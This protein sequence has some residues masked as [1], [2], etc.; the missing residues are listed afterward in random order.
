MKSEGELIAYKDAL[1]LIDSLQQEQP[2]E[3]KQVIII[4]ETDGDAN[5]YWDCRSLDDVK[6]L[7]ASAQSF[8]AD[9]QVEELRGQGS[10]PDYNTTEGRS[11]NA[12]KSQQ[13]Q[14]MPD[15]TQL[16]AEWEKEK[17]VLEQKDF[18]GDAE[19]MAYNAF[20]DGFVKGLG[21]EGTK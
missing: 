13:E 10:G 11:R 20:L 12:H 19:R 18:R 17:E 8:I 9:K 14:Q 2:I 4:T 7:L 6:A 1:S 16:I 21:Y 15:S 3:G 5:I